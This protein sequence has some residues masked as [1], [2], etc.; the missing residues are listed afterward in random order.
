MTVCP[1]RKQEK[2]QV[3]ST[4]LAILGIRG[5]KSGWKGWVSNHQFTNQ[6]LPGNSL[7]PFWDDEFTWPF[8]KA[9]RDLQRSGMKRSR[10]E[11]PGRLLFQE[12]SFFA[13]SSPSS[14]CPARKCSPKVPRKAGHIVIDRQPTNA[15]K[16]GDL[17]S[18]GFQREKPFPERHP[19]ILLMAEIWLTTWDV[20]NPIK[21]GIFS[22]PQQVNAGFQPSTVPPEEVQI[23][24]STW[25]CSTQIWWSFVA[26]K[27]TV[28]F[29]YSWQFCER[30]LF[31]VVKTWPLQRL[32]DL[33]RSGDEKVTAWITWLA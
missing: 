27:F 13:T 24:E 18:K 31:G 6:F 12:L 3:N 25:I 22:I 14:S 23:A 8:G 2:W 15:H 16:H 17:R 28:C 30:A 7:W 21:N 26:G 10:L 5:N 11:S 32:S 1:P 9:N 4:R 20:W 19:V 29:L 33:Q